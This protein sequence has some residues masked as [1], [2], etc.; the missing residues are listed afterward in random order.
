MYRCEA[1]NSVGNVTSRTITLNYYKPIFEQYIYTVGHGEKYVITADVNANPQ[2]VSYVWSSDGVNDTDINPAT[3]TFIASS[4]ED[5]TIYEISLIA[6]NLIGSTS[7]T[8]WIAVSEKTVEP[9]NINTGLI[10][11]ML[12]VGIFIGAVGL[13]IGQIIHNKIRKKSL[14]EKQETDKRKQETYMDYVGESGGENQT[15]QDLQ[16]RVEESAYVNVKAGNK[17]KKGK[18]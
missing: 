7:K 16:H 12:F 11:G 4:V 2:E 13:Y 18:V 10:I 8:M 9:R 15:Y 14:S 17:N 3:F 6:T 1:N 5:N